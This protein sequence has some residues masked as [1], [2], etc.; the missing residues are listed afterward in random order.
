[1]I[2]RNRKIIPTVRPNGILGIVS[3]L[4]AI[5]TGAIIQVIVY[6]TGNT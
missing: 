6:L 3:R 2:E 4:L 5:S 1:M